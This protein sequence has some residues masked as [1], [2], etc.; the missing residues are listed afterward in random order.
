V[1]AG[2]PAAGSFGSCWQKLDRGRKHADDL[3]REIRDFFAASPFQLE[4]AASDL[5][6]VTRVTVRQLDTIPA[7]IA[8]TAGDA[9]H[10]IR[11]A[12]DHFAWAAVS[13]SAQGNQTGFPVGSPAARDPAN[14]RRH[15]ERRLNGASPE[16]ISAVAAMEPWESGEDESLWAVHELDRLDKHRLVLSAAVTLGKIELHGDSYEL[17]TVK[18]YSGFDLDGPLPMEPAEWTP[19]EEGTVLAVPLT[20]PEMG[21]TGTTLRL[22]VVLAEPETLRRTS[23]ATAI[24]MLADSAEKAIRRLIPL[25]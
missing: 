24:T 2:S 18:K 11:S 22:D 6:G 1:V 8:L 20:G 17:T 25:A 14:W 23:A 19:V 4:P 9:A 5:A 13:P 10:N 7:S 15:V 3:S 12:L 21:G 16:L